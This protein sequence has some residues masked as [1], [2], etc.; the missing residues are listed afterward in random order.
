MSPNPVL[1]GGGWRGVGWS[2]LLHRSGLE[3]KFRCSSKASH[4]RRRGASSCFSRA[5]QRLVRSEPVSSSKSLSK[6]HFEGLTTFAVTCEPPVI[7]P[8]D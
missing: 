4:V 6:L 7:E 5:C 3:L 8:W 2:G 1:G